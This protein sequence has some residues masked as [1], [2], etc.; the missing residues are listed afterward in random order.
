M[1]YNRY[2]LIS[3]ARIINFTELLRSEVDLDTM[4]YRKNGMILPFQQH[5][6][7]FENIIYAIDMPQVHLR[8]VVEWR[9]L[10]LK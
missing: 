5:C 3:N 6:I 4:Q 1:S 8:Y 9:R 10:F 7:T 2:F